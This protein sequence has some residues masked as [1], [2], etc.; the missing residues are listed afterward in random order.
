[1]ARCRVSPRCVYQRDPGVVGTYT[2]STVLDEGWRADDGDGLWL[3]LG[4]VDGAAAIWVNGEFVGSQV[5]NERRWDVTDH[6]R[7]GTN[8]F[9]VK[10]RTTL[11]NAVTTY[12][13]NSTVTQ[14]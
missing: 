3:N 8:T 14:P 10:V 2:A 6:L 12:S 5:D 11:R 7:T 9:E 4:R 1:M 13:Q